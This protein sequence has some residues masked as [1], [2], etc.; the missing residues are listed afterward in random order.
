[1]PPVPPQPL[2]P[3]PEPQKGGEWRGKA[4]GE[5][6]SDKDVEVDVGDGVEVEEVI[7][8]GALLEALNTL[9]LG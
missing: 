1:M 6:G 7:L 8:K 9:K 2:A 3:S 5:V 4:E